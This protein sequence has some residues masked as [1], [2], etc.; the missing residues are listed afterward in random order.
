MGSDR[1]TGIRQRPDEWPTSMA[2]EHLDEVPQGIQA[3]TLEGLESNLRFADF[4]A[5]RFEI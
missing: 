1:R 5:P 2:R 4:K 3:R